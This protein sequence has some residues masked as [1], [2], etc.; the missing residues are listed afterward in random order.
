[1]TDRTTPLPHNGAEPV[2]LYLRTDGTLLVVRGELAF[3]VFLTPAQLVDLAI[4]QL[5]VARTLDP[6]LG[7]RVLEVLEHTQFLVPVEEVP[8]CK[9][10]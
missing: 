4:T 5:D 3:E 1:M 2:S 9:I 10:N 8:Q 6:A 7:G